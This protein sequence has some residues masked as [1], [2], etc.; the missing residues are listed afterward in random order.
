MGLFKSMYVSV[1]SY[2]NEANLLDMIFLKEEYMTVEIFFGAFHC[3][4]GIINLHGNSSLVFGFHLNLALFIF[5]TIVPF[6]F[7]ISWILTRSRSFLV[8]LL[9]HTFLPCKSSLL[10]RCFLHVFK[11]S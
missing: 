1:L 9:F 5:C 8:I 7:I 2:V 10:L 3:L 6:Y 11:M 4:L